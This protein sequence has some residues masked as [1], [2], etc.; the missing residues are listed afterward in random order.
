MHHHRVSYFCVQDGPGDSKKDVYEPKKDMCRDLT[1][2]QMAP[3]QIQAALGS[4]CTVGG[5]HFP[6]I[7][8]S[9]GHLAELVDNPAGIVGKISDLKDNTA[10]LRSDVS[11]LQWDDNSI[12]ATLGKQENMWR[13]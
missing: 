12:K 4:P 1:A 9:L 6:T 7:W 2:L 11:G 5:E 10:S 3:S 8:V 13:G